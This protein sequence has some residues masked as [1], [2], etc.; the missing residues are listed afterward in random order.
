VATRLEEI[1]LRAMATEPGQ[2]YPSMGEFA[3]DLEDFLGG[4][5]GSRP[6]PPRPS[7][8]GRGVNRK[9]LA[10]VLGAVALVGAACLAFLLWPKGPERETAE[11]FQQRV[12][13]LVR[14]EKFSEALEAV[15]TTEQ[16]DEVKTRA[17]Q[18][19]RDAA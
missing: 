10:L 9:A 16:P 5:P 6:R 2:R 13:G 19:A 8:K 7:Q 12:A 17:R 1:C 15:A 3:G 11:A 14:Q 18:E 4:A